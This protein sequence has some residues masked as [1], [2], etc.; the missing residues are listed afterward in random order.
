MALPD[1]VRAACT[2]LAEQATSVRIDSERLDAV[3]DDGPADGT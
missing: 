2:R 3:L 1:D